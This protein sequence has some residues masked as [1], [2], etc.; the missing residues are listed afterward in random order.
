MDERV[1]PLINGQWTGPTLDRVMAVASSLNFWLPF[2]VVLILLTAWFGRRRARV[3]LLALGLMLAVGDGVVS[4]TLK[5]LVHRPR[6]FQS[7]A[8]VR[9]V[10]LA[11]RVRPAVL[12]AFRPPVITRLS[13]PQLLTSPTAGRS[14]PSSHTLNNFCVATL[15]TL[16]YR[17]RGA[18]YFLPASLVAYSR[19]YVGSHWPSDVLISALL[20]AGAALLGMAACQ[21]VARR[22]PGLAT[23]LESSLNLRR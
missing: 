23:R 5:H 11:R 2:I 13:V 22:W 15:L 14:F 9:Q 20:G 4:N 3:F 16:F 7:V 8:D 21:A 6:P 12:A 19:V 18:L 10:D 1:F 17:W